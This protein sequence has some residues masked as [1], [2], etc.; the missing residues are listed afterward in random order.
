MDH[1]LLISLLT[2]PIE[3]GPGPS[4]PVLRRAWRVYRES[5][6]A[7]HRVLGVRPWSYWL[8]DLGEQ[9]PED[10]HEQ[11]VRL[12]ELGVLR[13]DEIAELRERAIA[14][15]VRLETLSNISVAEHEAIVDL[16]AAVEHAIVVNVGNCG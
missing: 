9:P 13:E 15:K 12:A 14:A 3:G 11:I 4:E 10:R 2:G 8:F 6:M 16:H 5:L 1:D 7:D